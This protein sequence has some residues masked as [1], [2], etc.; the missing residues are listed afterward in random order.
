MPCRIVEIHVAVDSLEHDSPT[1][2][3]GV[4]EQVEFALTATAF[5]R[6]S[7][8]LAVARGEFE[9]FRLDVQQL[10]AKLWVS[11]APGT[12]EAAVATCSGKPFGQNVHGPA[13]DELDASECEGLGSSASSLGLAGLIDFGRAEQVTEVILDADQTRIGDGTAG[14]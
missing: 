11:T 5:Q 2:T 14:Q 7:L 13:S 1:G 6:L 12:T 4:V 10:G 8:G 9:F 3:V